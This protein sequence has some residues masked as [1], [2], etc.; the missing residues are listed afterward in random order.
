MK[1]FM[2]PELDRDRCEVEAEPGKVFVEKMT[3]PPSRRRIDSWAVPAGRLLVQKILL[4][5]YVVSCHSVQ[6]CNLLR[7]VPT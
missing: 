7:E 2:S 1:Q 4:P 3:P 5:V 6:V